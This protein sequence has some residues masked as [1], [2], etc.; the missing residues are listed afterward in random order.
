VKSTNCEVPRYVIFFHPVT[1]Y[2]RFIYSPQYAVVKHPHCM[3]QI[4]ITFHYNRVV[5]EFGMKRS[6]PLRNLLWVLAV[7]WPLV[8]C[9]SADTVK[10]LL[11]ILVNAS[12]S[13]LAQRR[14]LVRA[15][16][17][18]ILLRVSLLFLCVT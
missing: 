1:S 18:A 12:R 9:L 8:A 14:S 11:F 16:R 13:T 15:P 2:F 17:G 5:C 7:I 3:F 4:I 10:K 6:V